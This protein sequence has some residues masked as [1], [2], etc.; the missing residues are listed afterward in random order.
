MGQLKKFHPSQVGDF[1][2]TL[3]ARIECF[4]SKNDRYLILL[5][6]GQIN[7]SRFVHVKNHVDSKGC[8]QNESRRIISKS[9]GND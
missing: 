8:V 4:F 7:F 1:S 6:C 2:P 3:E 9:Q 5:T